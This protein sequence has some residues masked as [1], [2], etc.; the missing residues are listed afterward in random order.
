MW[1]ELLVDLD[2]L[3]QQ[4][5]EKLVRFLILRSAVHHFHQLREVFSLEIEPI[6]KCARSFLAFRLGRAASVLHPFIR[7]HLA[8]ELVRVAEDGDGGHAI[9]SSLRDRQ[10]AILQYLLVNRLYL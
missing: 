6:G 3:P 1:V 4:K 2:L 5:V 7:A 8:Y 10:R 9:D